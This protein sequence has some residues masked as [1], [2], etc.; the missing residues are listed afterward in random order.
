MLANRPLSATEYCT[1]LI[2][3]TPGTFTITAWASST[4]TPSPLTT[5]QLVGTTSTTAIFT[6]TYT[7]DQ[8]ILLKRAISTPIAALIPLSCTSSVG[9]VVSQRASSACSCLLATSAT[10][11]VISTAVSTLPALVRR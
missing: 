1:S 9:P 4:V 2:S 8:T 3:Y 11:T 10:M 6:S 5:T 7:S